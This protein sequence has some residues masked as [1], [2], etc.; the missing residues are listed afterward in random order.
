MEE[1]DFLVEQKIIV[2]TGASSGIGKQIAIDVAKRGAIPVLLA[3][4]TEK[5]IEASTYIKEALGMDCYYY[6][7]DVSSYNDVNYTFEKINKE[8]GSPDVLINNAGFAI[9]DTFLEANF[10]EMKEMFDVN[11]IGLIACT[12]AV[13]PTMVANNK[14][15]IINIASQAGKISTPKSSAY[16]ATKHAVLGLTNSL[17]MELHDTNIHVSAVNPGPIQTPF[18]E[19]ADKSGSY[20]KNVE[21]MMLS[22]EYVSKKIVELIEKPK[23]EVNLPRWMN[24]ASTAYQ[25]FPSLVERLGGKQFHQK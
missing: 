21:K 20:T 1:S 3:R 25:V 10:H 22:T 2:I 24:V 16:S 7:V 6:T 19:R 11:V 4:S 8:V 13:L 12:K 23:R 18:F 17:R 5:L 15:H 9:F 14:G